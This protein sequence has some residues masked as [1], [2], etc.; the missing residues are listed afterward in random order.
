MEFSSW[1]GEDRSAIGL[2]REDFDAGRAERTS[3]PGI[4][5]IIEKIH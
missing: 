3:K 2:S 1:Q 4:F 5:Q